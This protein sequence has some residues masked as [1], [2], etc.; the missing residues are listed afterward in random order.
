MIVGLE[1]QLV[2][3]QPIDATQSVIEAFKFVACAPL[4]PTLVCTPALCHHAR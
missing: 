4:A 2:M 1:G 3:A